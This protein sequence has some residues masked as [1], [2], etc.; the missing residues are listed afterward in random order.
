MSLIAGEEIALA[1]IILGISS[2]TLIAMSKLWFERLKAR[3]RAASV[4]SEMEERLL[5]IE[6]AVD[7]IAIE[8][9]R[10]SE[11]QRFTTKILADRLPPA[12]AATAGT[13]PRSP[14]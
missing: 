8:V 3:D 10:M 2:G 9:E 5:R 12:P 4:P 11:S 6:Q 7:A 13:L 14:S 1:A